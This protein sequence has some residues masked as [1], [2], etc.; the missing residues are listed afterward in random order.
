MKNRYDQIIGFAWLLLISGDAD[1]AL[2][3]WTG[4]RS[5]TDPIDSLLTK[6]S[7]PARST[8]IATDTFRIS[9]LYFKFPFKEVWITAHNKSQRIYQ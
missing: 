3:E 4:I 7:I 5:E 9:M 6:H 1:E 8:V 2:R